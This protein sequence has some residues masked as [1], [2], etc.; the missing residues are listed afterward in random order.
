MYELNLFSQFH[1]IHSVISIIHLKKYF[2]DE[3]DRELSLSSLKIIDKAEQM[4]VREIINKRVTVD[5]EQKMLV[6]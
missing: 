1:D 2:E 5:E 6:Q 3:F 4:K